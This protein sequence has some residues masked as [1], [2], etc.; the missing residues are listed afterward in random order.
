MS[1]NKAVSVAAALTLGATLAACSGGGGSSPADAAKAHGPIKIWYSNNAAEV[2]WGKAMVSAWNSAHSK[3]AVTGQ[4]IPAGKSSEEVISAAIAAGN[5]PCLIYNTSPASVPGNVKQGGM[6]SLNTF[7]GATAY[8][9]ART[10]SRASQYKSPDGNYYQMPWKTNPVMIFYNKDVFTKAGVNAKNPP[11][12][13]Y[14]QF[15]AAAKTL[16]AKGGVQAAIWPAASSEFFQPWFDYYPL[17]IAASG[18]KAF[19]E[20]GKAQFTSPTGLEAARFWAQLYKDKLVPNES[21]TGDSFAAKKAAMAIVG[22]WAIATY[23]G[24]VNWGVVPVPTPNGMPANQI[25]TFSDEKSIGMFSACSNRGT[26]WDFLKFT[27][28]RDADGK[29]LQQTGQ[30]PMRTNLPTTYASYFKAHPKYTVFAAQAARTVEVPYVSN[31]VEAWQ[32]FR[33]AYSK[34]VIF[35]SADV[36]STLKNAATKINNLIAQK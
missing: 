29:L 33:N 22:P 15:T 5:A 25:H 9:E 17:F 1:N 23:S 36:A 3:E 6:V 16:V 13:T 4:Q 7:P 21:Y 27:T 20:N 34:A 2:S 30:M 31:S 28:S 12:R 32:T 24:K 18:G 26:A 35:G 19:V 11:L 14:A 8:I 10:G